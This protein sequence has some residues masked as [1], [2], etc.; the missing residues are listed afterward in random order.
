MAEEQGKLGL[1]F[2]LGLAVLHLS[3]ALPTIVSNVNSLAG[4]LGPYVVGVP[5]ALLGAGI[6]AKSKWSDIPG[7]LGVG[8]VGIGY[9]LQGATT[10]GL[11]AMG[12]LAVTATAIGAALIVVGF[13]QKQGIVK[14]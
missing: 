1:G 3:N 9:A 5:V 11:V 10:A 4:G 8:L 14:F 6:A 13:A 12:A 2:G 7:G